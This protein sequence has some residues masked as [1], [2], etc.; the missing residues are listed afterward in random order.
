LQKK[1]TVPTISKDVITFAR[2]DHAEDP[3]GPSRGGD[4]NVDKRN[5][6]PIMIGLSLSL[7]NAESKG[8][9]TPKDVEK[10]TGD[11]REKRQMGRS[12]EK[13][14]AADAYVGGE[15]EEAHAEKSRGLLMT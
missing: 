12:G 11:G 13:R 1:N 14:S 9:E 5:F 15:G 8:A 2:E 4:H 7:Q 3:T 10:I 6:K